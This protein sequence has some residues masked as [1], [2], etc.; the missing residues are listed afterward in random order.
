MK[1]ILFVTQTL[2]YGGG[3]I[4]GLRNMLAMLPA[5][6]YD[7]S[8]L[9]LQYSDIKNIPLDNCTILKNDIVL[10]AITSNYKH[11]VKYSH[12]NILRLIKI[13]LTL[14][15]KISLRNAA[16]NFLFRCIA[17]KYKNYDKV[18]AYQEGHCTLFAQYIDAPQLVAWI[19]CD[20]LQRKK[21]IK[22]DEEHIYRK[23][24]DIVCVSKYT[25]ESFLNIYPSLKNKSLY[26]H[27]ILNKK[28]ICQ[29]AKDK[30]EDF[31]EDDKT[32]KLISLGRIVPVKQFHLIP[33]IISRMLAMGA[34][35]FKWFLLGSTEDA[36]EYALLQDE[37][38][39]Y[40]IEDKYFSFL[41]SKLNP[42]PYIKNSDIMVSTSFSEACPYV[43]NE[44]RVLGVP[45]VS[46]NYPSIYEFIENNVNG[47]I[48]TIDDMAKVLSNLIINKN[49]YKK[50]KEGMCQNDYDNDT[51]IK[52]IIEVL[53]K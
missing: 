52:K 21:S 20:Y 41:G 1:K 36:K 10:T 30:V 11:T 9:P 48:C 7:I 37:L 4:S 46:N 28:S 14:L 16:E 19:H 49:E 12:R 23:Y 45:V 42:Y 15:S 18:I 29:A 38:I 2:N 32:M 51:I 44:A 39:K 8:I 40:N 3:V 50:I 34:N 27:N 47:C 22:F 24:N 53:D 26:I 6:R 5:D 35:N 31:M 25:L 33:S 13:I 43:V 17:R